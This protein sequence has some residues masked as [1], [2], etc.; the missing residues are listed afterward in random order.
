ML[1]DLWV[2]EGRAEDVYSRPGFIITPSSG[3]FSL[4]VPR[5]LKL[6]SGRRLHLVFLSDSNLVT[7]DDD[8]FDFRTRYWCW[9]QR[10]DE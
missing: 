10:Q 5:L 3:R 4:N 8:G 9:R 7:V 2:P 1:V 6:A